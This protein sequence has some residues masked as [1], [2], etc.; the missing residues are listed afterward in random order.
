MQTASQ[1][2]KPATTGVCPQEF[3]ALIQR[4]GRLE[5]VFLQASDD[6][7]DDEIARQDRAGNT[8]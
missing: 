4:V 1:R 3:K 2:I 6:I 8:D 7:V 5:A